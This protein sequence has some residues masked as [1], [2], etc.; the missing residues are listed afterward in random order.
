VNGQVFI[1]GQPLSEPYE[2]NPSDW[3]LPPEK[4]NANQYYV[5]GDNRSMPAADHMKGRVERERIIGK[6]IL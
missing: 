1:N 3:N 5:V 6:V 4:L 2:K